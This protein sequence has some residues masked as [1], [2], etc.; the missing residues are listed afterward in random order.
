M[1]KPLVVI[2]VIIILAAG[3]WL[4]FGRN[5]NTNNSAATPPSGSNSTNMASS[6]SSSNPTATNSVTIQNYAFSPSAITVKKGTSVTWTNQD[7][8]THTV[9][10]TDGK[11]GP[12]SGNLEPGKTYSFT[13]N[14]TGSFAYHCSIHTDMIG[15]VTV[16]E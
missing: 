12:S 16:T 11:T 8:V 5:S 13:Y 7:S 4:I 1:K 9:T 3:G 14:T 15:T 2:I 10:E 6:N